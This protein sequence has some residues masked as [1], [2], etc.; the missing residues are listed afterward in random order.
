MERNK[1]VDIEGKRQRG[2]DKSEETEQ[3][4]PRFGEETRRRI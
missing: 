4:R 1:G 2:K 3:K